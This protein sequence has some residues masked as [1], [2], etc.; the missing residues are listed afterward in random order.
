GHYSFVTALAAMHDGLWIA[1]GSWDG[2]IILWSIDDHAC[3]PILGWGAHPGPIKQLQ[4]SPNGQRLASSS[5]FEIRIWDTMHGSL[6]GMLLACECTRHS[7]CYS[8]F[9]SDGGRL[10][11]SYNDGSIIIWD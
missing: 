6:L 4:F 2:S 8:I 7:C 1:S 11:A 3:S 10:I 5:K 9:S